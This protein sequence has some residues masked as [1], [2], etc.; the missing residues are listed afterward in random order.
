MKSECDKGYVQL[1]LTGDSNV[2]V[3]CRTLWQKTS[4]RHLQE[5]NKYINPKTE[6]H[7]YYLYYV[8]SASNT[9]SDDRY[10]AQDLKENWDIRKWDGENGEPAPDMNEVMGAAVSVWN[11]ESGGVSAN[12]IYRN[13]W[14]LF[15]AM[16][17]AE[18]G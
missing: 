18:R 8:P 12:R 13:T 9:E 7:S 11:E 1:H 14:E 10:M 17:K 4:K 5:K 3:E 2:G 15:E 16:C 6:K